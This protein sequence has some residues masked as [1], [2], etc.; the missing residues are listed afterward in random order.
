[1]NEDGGEIMK[2]NFHF[3]SVS[4]LTCGKP[5]CSS[6]DIRLTYSLRP[7]AKES[8]GKMNVK[9]W[10]NNAEMVSELLEFLTGKKVSLDSSSRMSSKLGIRVGPRT[11]FIAHNPG[12]ESF[13]IEIRNRRGALQSG[14][15]IHRATALKLETIDQFADM[16]GNPIKVATIMTSESRISISTAPYLILV[17]T[18]AQP[19]QKIPE[20]AA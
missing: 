14:A 4:F 17:A 18:L 1:M 16:H 7:S 12:E 19:T 6:K 13:G 2:N 8:G 3:L 5:A 20:E 15:I 9:P 10:T 11:I